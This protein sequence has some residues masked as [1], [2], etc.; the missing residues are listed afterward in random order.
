MG[1]FL[2]EKGNLVT[3]NDSIAEVLKNQYQSVFSEP[4]EAKKI[5]DPEDFFKLDD[6]VQEIDNVIFGREEVID[7]LGKLSNNEAPGPDGIPSI[8]LLI[9]SQ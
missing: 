3:N 8:L 2:D 4:V 9:L 5:S 1:P 7:A 6:T